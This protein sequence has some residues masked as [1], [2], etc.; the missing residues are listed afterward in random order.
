MLIFCRGI[1]KPDKQISFMGLIS[2]LR[3][4][5]SFVFFLAI[6]LGLLFPE[7]T[8]FLNDY[9]V[10]FIPISLFFVFLKIDFS[11]MIGYMKR[12]L[13][14]IYII[15]SFLVLIPAAVFLCAV[16]IGPEYAVGFLLL[17][18]VPT[19]AMSAILV[20]MFKG[21]VSF[22]LLIELFLYVLSPITLPLIMFYLAGSVI[23]ID[24]F[25]LFLTMNQMLIIPLVAAQL[26]KRYM[27]TGKVERYSSEISIFMMAL[28]ALGIMGAQSAFIL[29]NLSTVLFFMAV[30][31]GLYVVINVAT[32]Y[33]AFWL[34]RKDRIT[35]S[36]SKTFMNG[37]LALVLASQFFSPEVV[38]V[39]VSNII[40]WFSYLG[41]SKYFIK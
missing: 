15:V 24:A 33:M 3:N 18:S 35:I 9:V 28:V 34:K 27:N 40:V 23:A 16:V 37:A 22:A 6:A 21:N 5:L 7:Y 36:V 38:L 1:N 32:Y 39:I 26:V 13:L 11:K 20:D 12:P 2:R 41:V 14:L 17:F 10:I 31:Y 30:L 8:A 25:G 4:N 19:A 29:G